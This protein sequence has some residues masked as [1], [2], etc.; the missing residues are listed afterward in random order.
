[1]ASAHTDK[2]AIIAQ[3]LSCYNEMAESYN[4][5]M[6]NDS[7][8]KLVREKVKE[9]FLDLL[10]SG[11]VLDFGGGTGLDLEWLTTA[12]YKIIF[13]EPSAAMREKA[14]HLNNNTLHN[15]NITFLD[16]PK[17]DFTKWA[18]EPPFPQ[19]MDAVLLNFGVL[20]YIPDIALLFKNIAGI[21][22]PGGHFVSVVLNLS[23]KKKFKAH[24]RNA[25]QSFIFGTPF[26]MY[27]P[28]KHHKQTVFVQSVKEIREAS[29]LYFDFRSSELVSP[30]DFILIQLV[31]NEKSI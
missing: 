11:W 29:S 10:Q 27:V 21:I 9:K 30:S 16:S 12:N 17:T 14:I 2:S 22:K 23:F 26:I 28:Y 4:N 31:R 13:C 19:K 20:N 25:I 18:L 6:H 15:A 5:T 8:N 3:N 24:R 7:S 1:M